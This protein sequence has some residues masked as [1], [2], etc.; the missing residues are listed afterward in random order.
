MNPLGLPG[1]DLPDFDDVWFHDGPWA[2]LCETAKARGVD[3]ATAWAAGVEWS[4][5]VALEVTTRRV[6][7]TARHRLQADLLDKGTPRYAALF[8]G[9]VLVGLAPGD[10]RERAWVGLYVK[11]LDDGDRAYARAL[12]ALRAGA[13]GVRSG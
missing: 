12:M 3:L 2:V 9:H 11:E 8:D 5:S 7:R 13:K 10:D 6:G 4:T 1:A